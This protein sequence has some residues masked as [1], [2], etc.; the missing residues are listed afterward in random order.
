MMLPLIPLIFIL[1]FV[2]VASRQG[3]IPAFLFPAPSQVFLVLFEERTA[4]IAAFLQ[5]LSDSAVGL[6]ISIVVGLSVALILSASTLM[7]KMFYPYAIF[8]QTVP[9]IAIAPLLVIWL[10]YGLPTVI[11]ASF[12]VSIFPVIANSVMGLLSTDVLLLQLFKT[13]LAI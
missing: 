1:A 4:F 11:A 13:F 10:G 3:M 2:E 5:T 6:A 7:R 9:I 8:F 12:I